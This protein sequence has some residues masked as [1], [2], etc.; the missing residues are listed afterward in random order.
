MTTTD[1]TAPSGR[2]SRNSIQSPEEQLALAVE[3]RVPI[4]HG[5]AGG[6]GEVVVRRDATGDGWA[7]TDGALTGVR[8]WTEGEGWR[9]VWDIG[10]AAAYQHTREGALALAHRVAEYEAAN[11]RQRIGVIAAPLGHGIRTHRRTIT[12]PRC[13]TPG[14]EE[15]GE[16]I[17][18]T[19]D[20]A[21]CARCRTCG[22]EW[23]LD[24]GADVS[25]TTCGG[26]GI[27]GAGP[28]RTRT[29]DGWEPAP[30][31]ECHASGH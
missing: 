3:F 4:P 16:P 22:H 17:D 21:D 30:Y 2:T 25:C 13:R 24:P 7:V 10:R 14:A 31:C 20:F 15:Y 1:H 11:H 9:P 18:G 5:P 23:A 8:A 6:P 29:P 28:S 12:C 19:D 26:S 27:P